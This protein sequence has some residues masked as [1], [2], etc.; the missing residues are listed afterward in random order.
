MFI[1][2]ANPVVGSQQRSEGQVN[3]SAVTRNKVV[4]PAGRFERESRALISGRG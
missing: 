3:R 2:L 4:D 1:A